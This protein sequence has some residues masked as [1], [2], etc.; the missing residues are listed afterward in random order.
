MDSQEHKETGPDHPHG[1]ARNLVTALTNLMMDDDPTPPEESESQP[2]PDSQRPA[3]EPEHVD[4]VLGEITS[5]SSSNDGMLNGEE[6][7]PPP[8]AFLG[9]SQVREALRRA[10]SLRPQGHL[11][12]EPY[13]PT[14]FT[15]TYSRLQD[16]REWGG[17][18]RDLPQI[19]AYPDTSYG[20]QYPAILSHSQ[21]LAQT[22]PEIRT[23]FQHRC[24][25]LRSVRALGQ[26]MSFTGSPLEVTNW[27]HRPLLP[28][29][30]WLWNMP[31]P[32]QRSC[33]SNILFTP[34]W[35]PPPG[36]SWLI[37]FLES[38]VFQ[39]LAVVAHQW[40]IFCKQQAPSL[41][42]IPLHYFWSVGRSPFAVATFWGIISLRLAHLVWQF[43]WHWQDQIFEVPTRSDSK[44]HLCLWP[45]SMKIRRLRSLYPHD[46]GNPRSRS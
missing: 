29:Q 39:F 15:G 1:D 24:Y 2:R 8:P 46:Q 3:T 27:A 9:E 11:D 10:D 5:K 43:Q 41:T 7:S 42:S 20:P 13:F 4:A 36:T 22:R 19:V 6:Q 31:L 26:K 21:E 40:M 32:H 45:G 18:P 33:H 17:A 25:R 35:T 28:Q 14:S 44:V 12:D 23:R 37:F 38:V 16:E 34:L 30:G